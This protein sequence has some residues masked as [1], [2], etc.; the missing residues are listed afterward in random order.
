LLTHTS[1]L[2]EITGEQ[3]RNCR[4]LA[5]VIP[6]YA[7]RPL[8]FEPGSRWV[9]CQS[10]INTAARVVEV[11]SGRSFPEFL[12]RNLF[13]PLGM[14]DTTFYVR[15]NQLPRLAKTYRRAED[16][17]LEGTANAFLMGRS[18]TSTDRF[19]AANGGLY[20]TAPDYARFAQMLLNRGRLGRRRYLKPESVELMTRIHTGDLKTG[21]TEGN[22]WGIGFCVIREPQGVT[23]M[24]SSGTFGHGGAHGT[25]AWID[26]L[27][28][29]A[30]ILMV[31]RA[32][33]PN[34]DASE[35]RRE[36]QRAAAENVN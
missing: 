36:F 10:S 29:L 24:L 28:G 26:P 32:N 22:G 34:A 18:P 2:A 14:K 31:Q 15:E 4:A 19:P 1:G 5:D 20:S 16:G 25:Q 9:Y 17:K 12:A 7:A 30:Y 27:K 33:F 8:Q 35:L 21:F 6:L 23:S 11:V 3:A 13:R